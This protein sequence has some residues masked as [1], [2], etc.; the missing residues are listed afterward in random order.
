MIGIVLA[1]T[2]CSGDSDDGTNDDGTTED[3]A[4]ADDDQVAGDDDPSTDD[5]P[6]D[7]ASSDDADDTSMTVDAGTTLCGNPGDVGN[8]IGVGK[9]CEGIGDCGGE[10][11]LCSDI[12]DPNT[13]FCTKTCEMGSTDQCGTGAECVC[14]DSNQCGCTPSVCLD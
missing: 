8:E 4:T 6:A 3:D 11:W 1:F 12:G 2:A 13:H 14:N 7:D 10:A 9:Y 5:L